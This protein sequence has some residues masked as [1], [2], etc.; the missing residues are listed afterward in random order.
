MSDIKKSIGMFWNEDSKR[1]S[2]EIDPDTKDLKCD[3]SFDSD[4]NCSL[5]TDRRA[6]ASEKSKSEL[7]RGWEGDVL[8]PLA[9]YL[10]G[11]KWWLN[12]QSRWRQKTVNDFVADT[13]KSLEHFITRELVTSIDVKGR[14]LGVGK[15]EIKVIF[16]VDSNEVATFTTQVWQNSRYIGVNSG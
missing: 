3:D 4:I 12:K 2:M 16:Y 8:T 1:F 15:I 6:D 10:I 7:R 14:M 13:R 5:F 11:S 9:E